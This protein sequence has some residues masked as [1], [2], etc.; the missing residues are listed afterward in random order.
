V[1]KGK[2]R[3]RWVVYLAGSLN[4]ALLTFF[5]QVVSRPWQ[6]MF[7]ALAVLGTL[8]LALVVPRGRE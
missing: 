6:P 4:V 8:V 5:S 3:V 1:F 2:N 7:A